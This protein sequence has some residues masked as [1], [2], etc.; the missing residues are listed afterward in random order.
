MQARA[1]LPNDEQRY[2]LLRKDHKVEMAKTIKYAF[3]DYMPNVRTWLFKLLRCFGC[4]ADCRVSSHSSRAGCACQAPWSTPTAQET[5]ARSVQGVWCGAAL[6]PTPEQPTNRAVFTI[7]CC[8][9]FSRTTL[10]C[11]ATTRLI[12]TRRTSSNELAW[13]LV[14]VSTARNQRVAFVCNFCTLSRASHMQILVV[15]CT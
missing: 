11:K 6:S 12:W 4:C 14:R 8:D 3:I 15:C 2:V 7:M 5:S 1:H 9:M 13:L 10:K